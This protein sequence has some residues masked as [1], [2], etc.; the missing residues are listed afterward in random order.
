VRTRSNDR[1]SFDAHAGSSVVEQPIALY[2]GRTAT[3]QT[4]LPPSSHGELDGPGQ[5]AGGDHPSARNQHRREKYNATYKT[6]TKLAK[7]IKERR[8]TAC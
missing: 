6:S 4:I 8:P 7:N 2:S 3:H 1:S 5:L